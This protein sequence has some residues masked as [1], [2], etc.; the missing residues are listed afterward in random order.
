[1]D[2][3]DAVFT[4]LRTRVQA[5][6]ILQMSLA[7]ILMRKLVLA[8]TTKIDKNMFIGGDWNTVPDKTLDVHSADPLAYRNIGAAL[9]DLQ[10]FDVTSD[11][12]NPQ[13]LVKLAANKCDNP[14]YPFL[15]INFVLF[16]LH[17]GSTTRRLKMNLD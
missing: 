13:V 12:W 16:L 7:N 1:M 2:V 3:V 6:S 5:I 17:Y 8:R 10:C 9:L 11:V 4:S 15:S 14:V